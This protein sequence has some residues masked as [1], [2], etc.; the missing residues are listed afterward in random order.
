MFG[1]HICLRLY[2]VQT[3]PAR[4]C[5]YLL[6]AKPG[7]K[8]VTKG[9]SKQICSTIVNT[10]SHMLWPVHVWINRLVIWQLVLCHSTSEVFWGDPHSI[11]AALFVMCVKLKLWKKFKFHI[12]LSIQISSKCVR[13]HKILRVQLDTDKSKMESS[14][15]F[16]MPKNWVK[17]WVKTDW[18][19]D[20]WI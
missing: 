11:N 14:L 5:T 8:N 20:G 18:F 15:I 13:P 1:G 3:R 10:K 4:G 6:V 7:M 12:S 2:W 16:Q 9:A 19:V 17:H